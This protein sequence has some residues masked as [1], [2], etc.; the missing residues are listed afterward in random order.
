LYDR[1]QEVLLEGAHSSPADVS[2]GVPQGTVLGPLLFLSY[3]NDLPAVVHTSHTKLFTDDCLLFKDVSTDRDQQ[4]LQ[5]DLS[6]LK[7]WE[8]DWQMEFNPGKCTVIRIRPSKNKRVR[9]TSYT[10]HNETLAITED[11]KYL[12]VTIDHTLSWSKHTEA[13]AG[14]ANKTLG[15]V[16]QNLHSCSAQVKAASY[17]TM[18]RPILEYAS[19]AWD[20]YLQRNINMLE[21]VQRRAAR[22]ACN[23][24]RDQTPGCVEKMLND[25]RWQPLEERRKTNRLAFLHKINNGL[26][27][28]NI[29]DFVRRS[30]P[31][32][33]GAQRFHQERAEHPAL[34]HSF[35]P[36]T[37]REWNN[38]HCPDLSPLPGGVWCRPRWSTLAPPRRP[39]LMTQPAVYIV[40]K[41]I[42][43]PA[44]EF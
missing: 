19:S 22:F 31:R 24:Y 34:Y 28:I 9:E 4:V 17:T 10:L 40:L 35:F 2:S 16:R 29:N 33:R 15:F 8:T 12:G 43:P 14:K 39:S 1:K 18:V 36:R 7:Q 23:S 38:P 21:T 3:I 5:S 42:R 20:P 11:S 41:T 6:A 25:L 37:L 13:T 27:D 44:C 26:V 30:D 32:T